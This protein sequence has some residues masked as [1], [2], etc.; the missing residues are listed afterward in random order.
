MFGIEMAPATM[1]ARAAAGEAATKRSRSANAHASPRVADV[2]RPAKPKE[3]VPKRRERTRRL[4]S[5]K[6]R[7]ISERMR[8]YW[9]ARRSLLGKQKASKSP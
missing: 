6:R 4:T 2:I 7:A 5:A 3:P 1:P 9:A 8:K